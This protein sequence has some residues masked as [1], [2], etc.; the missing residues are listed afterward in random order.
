VCRGSGDEAVGDEIAAEESAKNAQYL[1]W[2]LDRGVTLRQMCVLQVDTRANKILLD[3][4]FTRMT[5]WESIILHD[6][7]SNTDMHPWITACVAAV[8]RNGCATFDRVKRLS[9]NIAFHSSKK[10]KFTRLSG[11]VKAFPNLE[12]VAIMCDC[13][14]IVDFKCLARC[15]KLENLEIIDYETVTNIGF[16][17]DC[18]LLKSLRLADFSILRDLSPLARCTGLCSIDLHHV[19]VR[20]ISFMRQC[21]NLHT[22]SLHLCDNIR[23]L[24]PLADVPNLHTLVLDA[25]DPEPDEEEDDDYDDDFDE[26]GPP[27]DISFFSRCRNLQSITLEECQTLEDVSVLAQCPKLRSIELL[28]CRFLETLPSLAGLSE[29]RKIVVEQCDSLTDLSFLEGCDQLKFVRLDAD[30]GIGDLSVLMHL[31][32]ARPDVLKV[33][34]D[35]GCLVR[36]SV[37]GQ[38]DVVEW[39]LGLGVSI[40]ATAADDDDEYAEGDRAT[41]LMMACFRGDTAR[42]KWLVEHGAN[43]NARSKFGRSVLSFAAEKGN[44]AVVSWLLEHPTVLNEINSRDNHNH[45]T[46]LE[47]AC[48]KGHVKASKLLI[49]H[50]AD[51]HLASETGHTPLYWAASEGCADVARLLLERGAQ[52]NF[53]GQIS[54]EYAREVGEVYMSTLGNTPLHRACSGGHLAVVKLL[55]QH[56]A[57]ANL[58][59]NGGQT[60]LEKALSTKRAAIAKLIASSQSQGNGEAKSKGTGKGAKGCTK[61]KK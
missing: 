8:E 54:E 25:M 23:D 4:L 47:Y 12:G 49:D 50:G 38:M 26:H 19:G 13:N 51:I 32:K 22:V 56:G 33:D 28:T 2:V 30:Y 53:V 40:D 1:R 27:L 7:V 18:K 52:A 15:A 42:A 44:D 46:P 35:K 60:P 21:P 29:L 20:D 31:Q 41:A 5:D 10:Q 61:R 16:I 14:K 45:L 6:V 55:L 9:L 48:F 3:R 24:S 43:I 17:A 34:V 11:L 37:C 59:N 57:D 39:L 58:K 36:A